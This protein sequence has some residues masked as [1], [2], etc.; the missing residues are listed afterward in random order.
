MLSDWIDI[1]DDKPELGK[2]VLICL[3]SGLITV[4][5]RK[6]I[7]STFYWQVFGEINNI[8]DMKNDEVTHWM[9]L[10]GLPETNKNSG[11]F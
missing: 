8:V 3:K 10:P 9:F 4:G 6:L 1:K 5:Y 7:N 11:S 2:G